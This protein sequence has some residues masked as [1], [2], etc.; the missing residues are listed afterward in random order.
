MSFLMDG[1][2]GVRRRG[3]QSDLWARWNHELFRA[4][5]LEKNENWASVIGHMKGSD[6]WVALHWRYSEKSKSDVLTELNKLHKSGCLLFVLNIYGNGPR[7]IGFRSVNKLAT[8]SR[9]CMRYVRSWTLVTN[10]VER[11]YSSGTDSRSGCQETTWILWNPKIHY[12][13]HYSPLLH[14]AWVR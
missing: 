11:R 6:H 2:D 13:A 8:K 14:A 5:I 10:P 4:A 7:V 3:I 1:Q 9:K 12:R